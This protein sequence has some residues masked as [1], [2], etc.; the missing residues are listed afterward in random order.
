MWF[1]SVDGLEHVANSTCFDECESDPFL[2][3]RR[4]C[5]LETLSGPREFV[6]HGGF[7]K[8]SKKPPDRI[9]EPFDVLSIHALGAEDSLTLALLR[10]IEEILHTRRTEYRFKACAQCPHLK[11]RTLLALL[12]EQDSQEMRDEILRTLEKIMG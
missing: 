5:L 3:A 11:Y 9:F 8:F 12:P 2:I 10:P 4:F 6:P 7:V 1:L